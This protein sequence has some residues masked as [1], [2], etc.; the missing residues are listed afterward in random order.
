MGDNRVPNG[1]RW[2]ASSVL[3]VEVSR[4]D[5]LQR[6]GHDAHHHLWDLSLGRHPWL[7]DGDQAIRA[8]GDIGYLRQDFLIPDYLACVGAEPVVGSVYV[9]AAWDRS[10]PPE[11]EVDW[12]EA[13]PRPA[14]IA[15]R[16][17]AWAP[18][19]APQRDAVLETLAQ[20]PSV[21]GVRETVRWHPDPAKRWV[22]AGL[23]DDPA[24]REGV[25]R[26]SRHQL[27]LELLMNPYQAEALARLA[28]DVPE[29][30]FV[31]NHCGT[32]IDRDEDGLARWRAGLALMAR[33]RNIAIK[34]SN[35]AA[36]SPD[37][38]PAALRATVMTCIDA[39]GPDRCLFGSDYPVARRHLSY[40]ETCA[41]FRE[42]VADLNAP[43]QRRIFHDNAA[44]LYG[45]EAN[46]R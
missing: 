25:A 30:R 14:G 38:S 41:R 8:L 3:L 23:M 46:A 6:P 35:F 2:V 32:P 7:T 44:R 20:R 24:W 1:C 33:E 40:G 9:E 19:R 31:I 18:L 11:E 13:L 28:A 37:H 21:V 10:R 39:F 42:A 45:F 34:L 36:Y 29:Q 26:L 22:E 5:P 16:S 15:A 4:D 17:I 27:L 12:L 43:E